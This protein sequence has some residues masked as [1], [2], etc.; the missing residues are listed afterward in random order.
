M[1]HKGTLWSFRA[2][3][4]MSTRSQAEDYTVYDNHPSGSWQVLL[5]KH[6]GDSFYLPDWRVENDQDVFSLHLTGNDVPPILSLRISRYFSHTSQASQ[7]RVEG[8]FHLPARVQV[9]PEHSLIRI[10]LLCDLT[11][12][13]NQ[14]RLSVMPYEKLPFEFSGGSSS[15]SEESHLRVVSP[16]T[17][18]EMMEKTGEGTAFLQQVTKLQ[19]VGDVRD[20]LLWSG[21]EALRRR[22]FRRADWYFE[23]ARKADW[24]RQSDACYYRGLT[25]LWQKQSGDAVYYFALDRKERKTALS[26]LL[27]Q[28]SFMCLMRHKHDYLHYPQEF[29]E[30][31]IP[32]RFLE[33]QQACFSGDVF[34]A[35]IL[36]RILRW[37]GVSE[38]KHFQ[39]FTLLNPEQ[40]WYE[41][42]WEGITLAELDRHEEAQ[43]ALEQSL[44]QGMPPVL[45][46][47]LAW[48]EE[49]QPT[50][51]NA[52]VRPLFQ[53]HRL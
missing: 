38:A 3:G 9:I 47:P 19:Q 50:F 30:E 39:Q 53:K 25:S 13:P 7:Q 5:K 15:E 1:A 8:V 52:V 32:L 12:D 22:H 10:E 51:L 4:A 26:F 34:I 41:R 49:S 27:E 24:F 6:R 23:L 44:A 48:L 31:E 37:L 20:T 28:W 21:R 2:T 33:Q 46:R 17:I 40:A 42:F 18:A 35:H 45:L 14:G 16:S 29:W 36:D 11:A 43:A